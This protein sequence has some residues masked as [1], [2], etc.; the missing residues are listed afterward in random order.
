MF[1]G[2]VPIWH[3]T[4]PVRHINHKVEVVAPLVEVQQDLGN[5]AQGIVKGE[6]DGMSISGE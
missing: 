3:M 1:V 4:I 5:E 6:V 2:C